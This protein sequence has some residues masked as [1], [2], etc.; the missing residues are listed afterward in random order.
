MS[1]IAENMLD[2]CLQLDSKDNMSVVIVF[3]DAAPTAING[4]TPKVALVHR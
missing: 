1:K 4:H 3:F 2:A